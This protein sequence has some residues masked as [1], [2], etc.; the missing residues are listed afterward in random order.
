METFLFVMSHIWIQSLW[1]R[2]PHICIINISNWL[3]L[4]LKKKNVDDNTT[5]GN[6]FSIYPEEI[7]PTF[8]PLSQNSTIN[9]K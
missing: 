4:S 9:N 1:C 5:C 3:V 2:L 8:P 6:H 7:I